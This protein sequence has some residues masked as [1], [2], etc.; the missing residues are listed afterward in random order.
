[1]SQRKAKVKRTT[2]ETQI[3]LEVNLDGKGQCDS[4]LD[5]GFLA[6]MLELL[7]HHARI[8]LKLRA[9]GDLQVDDHHLTEDLGISI[10]EAVGKALGERR[11]IVR[12][13]SVLLPMDEVLVAVA[14]D[15]GG[16]FAF[17]CDYE[18]AREQVGDLSTELI[19]HFFQSLANSA[20]CNLHFKFLD[21]GENEHHRVE[22]M[23]KGFARALRMAVQIDPEGKGATPSTKGVI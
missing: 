7:A 8:D 11:G 4:T 17:R 1:M 16:R 5:L 14:L 2:R 10:G 19:P 21:E 20:R 22:A 12:Y 23:F 18:P 3:E 13:G 6:H 15:L 9:Q